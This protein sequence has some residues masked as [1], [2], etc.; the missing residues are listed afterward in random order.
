MFLSILLLIISS[1]SSLLLTSNSIE[2]YPFQFT[3]FKCFLS[4][5]FHLIPLTSKLPEDFP[6]HPPISLLLPS[7]YSH[8]HCSQTIYYLVPQSFSKHRLM[9][10]Y[11]NLYHPCTQ[12]LLP[13]ASS[14]LPQEFGDLSIALISICSI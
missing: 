7:F 6:F 12:H 3:N 1:Q 5:F 13:P 4:S 14:S 9:P 10:E 2:G 11:F 8:L